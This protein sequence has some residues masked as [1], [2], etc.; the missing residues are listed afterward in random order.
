MLGNTCVIIINAA[1][2]AMHGGFMFFSLI[3]RSGV[4]GGG[5]VGSERRAEDEVSCNI[6]NAALYARQHIH[7]YF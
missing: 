4:R 1:F 2:S 7:I 6:I 3:K 5:G